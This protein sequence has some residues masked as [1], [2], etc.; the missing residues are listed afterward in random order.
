[1]LKETPS[2]FPGQRTEW[3]VRDSAATVVLVPDANY[4]SKGTSFTIAC[5]RKY[6]KACMVIYY[7]D[8]SA[9]DYLRDAVR[10]LKG[11][12]SLNIA[13]PRESEHQGSYNQCLPILEK[14][15]EF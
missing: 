9:A 3:N 6:G 13:G 5:A 4:R 10:R 2:E 14:A 8:D 11:G 15:L 12:A 1:M 7:L